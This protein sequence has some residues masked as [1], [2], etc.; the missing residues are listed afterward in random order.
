MKRTLLKSATL[1]FGSLIPLFIFIKNAASID[2]SLSKPILHIEISEE[3]KLSGYFTK[4]ERTIFFEAIRGEKNPKGDPGMPLFSVDARIMDGNHIPFVYQM[5]GHGLLDSDWKE[6]YQTYRDQPKDEDER[7]ENFMMLPALA[8][9]L[10]K[11]VASHKR[12]KHEIRALISLSAIKQTELYD[13]D[14]TASKDQNLAMKTNQIV[15]KHRISIHKKKAWDRLKYDH[16]AVKLKIYNYRSGKLLLVF[17][18][19]NHGTSAGDMNEKC[20][21][22]LLKYDSNIYLWDQACDALGF[23]YG[24]HVCN[25]DTKQE[26]QSQYNGG[27]QH[28]GYCV[29][30][31]PYAPDCN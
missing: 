6:E 18:T 4:D 24:A 27:T 5:G 7:E 17:S 12:Y 21:T 20:N 2:E 11:Y 8:K 28:W 31:M 9:A 16:S 3:G 13:L 14:D 29:P 22:S 1:F 30:I 15:Y 25:N 19:A 10:K 26:F 23:P